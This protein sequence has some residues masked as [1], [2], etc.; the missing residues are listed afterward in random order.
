MGMQLV[1]ETSL[2]NFNAEL[3]PIKGKGDSNNP[4]L[5]TCHERDNQPL[6]KKAHLIHRKRKDARFVPSMLGHMQNDEDLGEKGDSP[7]YYTYE[8]EELAKASHVVTSWT[9]MT[10]IGVATPASAP[11]IFITGDVRKKDLVVLAVLIAIIAYL[12]QHLRICSGKQT[13][14]PEEQHKGRRK[15]SRLSDGRRR[16]RNHQHADS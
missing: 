12:T 6:M 13:G 9:I 2:F 10:D 11:S 15:Y 8:D 4:P 14:T 5:A 16:N 3:P 7:F 1:V